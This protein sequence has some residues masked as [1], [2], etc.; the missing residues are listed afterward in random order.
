MKEYL[1]GNFRW[2]VTKYEIGIEEC[3]TGKVLHVPKEDFAGFMVEHG[4]VH[5]AILLADDGST[6]PL[7]EGCKIDESKA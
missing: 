3:N 1:T 7:I 4:I 2:I 6:S 5:E